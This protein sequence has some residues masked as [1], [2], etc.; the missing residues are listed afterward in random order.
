MTYPRHLVGRLKAGQRAG[1]CHAGKGTATALG[2]A[3]YGFSNVRFDPDW[4]TQ[5]S[6]RCFTEE[7]QWGGQRDLVMAIMRRSYVRLH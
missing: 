2:G 6:A 1:P 7:L 5:G 3:G 4:M